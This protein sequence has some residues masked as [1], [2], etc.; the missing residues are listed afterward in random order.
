MEL[1]KVNYML[2]IDISRTEY[3]FEACYFVA[4]MGRVKIAKIKCL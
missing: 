1:K 3:L 4:I 2:E